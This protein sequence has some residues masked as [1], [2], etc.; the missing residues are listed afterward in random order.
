MKT[1]MQGDRDTMRN[2]RERR[3][4]DHNYANSKLHS[5]PYTEFEQEVVAR[6]TGASRGRTGGQGSGG[7]S[8]QEG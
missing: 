3:V 7:G 8:S 1:R 6:Q 5:K 2:N 4:F